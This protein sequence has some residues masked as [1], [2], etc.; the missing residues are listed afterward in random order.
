MEGSSR[1]FCPC[2][3]QARTHPWDSHYSP[4]TLSQSLIGPLC[5]CTPIPFHLLRQ[6][7]QRQLPHHGRRLSLFSLHSLPALL[8]LSVRGPTSSSVSRNSF[9]F[10]C[11][12]ALTATLSPLNS[13]MP[14]SFPRD[15]STKSYRGWQMVPGTEV[16]D[17]QTWLQLHRACSHCRGS[18]LPLPVQADN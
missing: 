12:P 1:C 7:C 5:G 9:C 10:P 4:T 13:E 2:L 16:W 6:E 15:G 3:S 14:T 11:P 17:K 18:F 8:P